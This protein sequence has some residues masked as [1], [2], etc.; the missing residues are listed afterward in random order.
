MKKAFLLTEAILS[1]VVVSIIIYITVN[2]I[3]SLNIK[4]NLE[5]KKM[6]LKLDFENSVFFL[7]NKKLTDSNLTKLQYIDKKL[8]YDN[9]VLLDNV[10]LFTKKIQNDLI[11]LKICIYSQ[12]NCYI[13][14][15]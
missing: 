2:I 8:I 5:Y 13:C 10:I 14:N 12:K 7:K 3:Y 9:V 1:F 4:N 6:V 11:E 15:F